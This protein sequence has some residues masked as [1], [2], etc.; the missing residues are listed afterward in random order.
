QE[1][2]SQTYISNWDGYVDWRNRPAI[3]NRHGGLLAAS[4]VLGVEVLE[5]LAFLANAS[6]LVLY[7]SEY[8]HFSPT[9]SANCVT[10]FMGTAF[11]LALLGG[12]LSDAF[13]T[14]YYIYLISSLIEFLGLVVLT[15]QA[16][17]SSLKPPK[18]D[19]G[20]PDI[21]CEQVHGAQ[22]AM[23]FIGLYLVA[24]GVGGIK[25]SLPPH[26]AEQFDETTPQGRKQRSTFFNYFVFC[27]SFGGLIAVTFVVWVEDNKGWQWGFGIATLAIFLSIPIFLAGSPFYR[28][29][30][31]R[32]SP[33]TTISKVLI[34]ALLNSRAS[35]NLSTVIASMVS[36]PPPIPTVKEIGQNTN[37]K[38]IESI[39]TPS[40]SLGFLNRAVSDAP[41]CSA[42]EC[43]VQQVE[44]VKIV[45]KLFPVFACTI[46]LNCCLAQLNTFSVHQAATMNTKLGSL[47]VP[48]ASLPIFPVLFIMIL[49]PVYDHFIIPFARRLTKTEMGISHLQRIGIGLFLSIVAMAVAAL[50]EIK[51]KGVATDSGLIDYAKPLPITFFWIAFQYLFLGSAD[52]FVLAGLLE[53]C[54]SEAPVSMRSL[55]TSLSWASLAIGYYL[56]SVIVSIV[57]SVTGISKHKPW[58]SG[59]NLNHYHLERFYW[60]MCILS[61]LN[62]MHYLFW[63]TKYK[64]RSR[65]TK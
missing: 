36:S 35:R 18:C 7:F 38:D 4:F 25:G 48:P 41:A 59:S 53:F 3:T 39:D 12:F 11:L 31:P 61:A 64:Y 8:M 23:L 15:I 33:L 49:A 24:L 1:I 37:T 30:I 58:L 29:K 27:L 26:G 52:L 44:E 10:N 42:L 55:A 62:F 19:Q 57:N 13:F 20:V 2:D 5:N 17:S 28:N 65:S 47:K 45:L 34:A 16:R 43:T 63:A 40:R 56:S 9:T 22:A 32:G 14:T 21:P 50:V 6:N 46:M 51:R 54:F 60:L